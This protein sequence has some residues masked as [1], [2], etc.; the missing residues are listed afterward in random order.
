MLKNFTEKLQVS[1]G[2]SVEEQLK[3]INSIRETALTLP[4]QHMKWKGARLTEAFGMWNEGIGMIT[5]TENSGKT[6]FTLQR[7]D[8]LFDLNDDVAALDVTIDDSFQSRSE[9]YVGVFSGL[10]TQ[11]VSRPVLANKNELKR[12]DEGYEKLISRISEKKLRIASTVEGKEI[13]YLSNIL[14]AIKDFRQ[15][16]GDK[17]LI[18]IIDSLSDIRLPETRTEEPEKIIL[19]EIDSVLKESKAI[20]LMTAHRRK[21]GSSEFT[22]R[23]SNEELKGSAYIKYFAKHLCV[24]HNE[25][26]AKRE[27]ANMFWAH[28]NDPS[29]RLPVIEISVQKNKTSDFDD[30]IFFKFSPKSGASMEASPAEHTMF[31]NIAME[32][33][34]KPNFM[35]R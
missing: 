30:W 20:C 10:A 5:G 21:S 2:I 24:V 29:T 13:Y 28:P 35:G 32:S 6:S 11:L 17:K 31:R 15:E 9:R 4:P 1:S 22:R 26:K 7:T 3:H 34:R 16:A 14:T 33:F 19:Q 27:E 25:M 18:V 12:R 23:V 8:E